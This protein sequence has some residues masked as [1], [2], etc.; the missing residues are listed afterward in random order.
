MNDLDLKIQGG[1]ICSTVHAQ[2]P[3]RITWKFTDGTEVVTDHDLSTPEGRD[4]FARAAEKLGF[5][6]RRDILRAASHA[7]FG[8]GPGP[9]LPVPPL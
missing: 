4:A 9:I 8:P 6:N 7:E 1:A 5:G 3:D 2:W